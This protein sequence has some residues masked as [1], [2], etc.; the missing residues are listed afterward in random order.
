MLL[1][2]TLSILNC[3]TALTLKCVLARMLFSACIP[4]TNSCNGYNWLNSFCKGPMDC[5]L[6]FH[7]FCQSLQVNP[8]TVHQIRPLLLP[9]GSIPVHYSWIMM[10]FIAV[11]YDTDSHCNEMDGVLVCICTMSSVMCESCY[12]CKILISG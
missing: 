12:Y 4:G 2:I 3:I 6:F 7:S 8:G 5:S 10:P 1:L 11:C 9:S